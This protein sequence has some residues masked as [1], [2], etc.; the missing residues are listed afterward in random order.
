[1]EFPGGITG[2]G[3]WWPAGSSRAK[4]LIPDLESG[5]LWDRARSLG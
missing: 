5:Y 3:G 4:F 2:Y 1:M